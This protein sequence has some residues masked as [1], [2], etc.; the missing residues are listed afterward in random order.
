MERE[1]DLSS[2]QSTFQGDS[3]LAVPPNIE[4]HLMKHAQVF[5]P[6]ITLGEITEILVSDSQVERQL[7]DLSLK[8]ISWSYKKGHFSSY[9]IKKL[10][11]KEGFSHAKIYGLRV[12]TEIEQ[13]VVL[14]DEI[15]ITIQEW[16]RQ[17]TPDGVEVQVS[18]P[19]LLPKWKIPR[20]EGILFQVASSSSSLDKL[21]SVTLSALFEGEEISQKQIRLRLTLFREAFVAKR[22]IR[23]GTFITGEQVQR[24]RVDI[25]TFRGNEVIDEEQF[26]G[27]VARRNI[28]V[29]KAL[30]HLDFEEP[31]AIMKGSSNQITLIN[32][33]VQMNISRAIAL[34][35]GKR[36]EFILFQNPLNQREPIRAEV[37]DRGVARILIGKVG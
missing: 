30:S 28:Q 20:M 11:A 29:G 25:S 35:D 17:R 1:V 32:Q 37:I 5:P 7:S 23:K 4:I 9:Q 36:G 24:E 33:G 12:Y 19:S 21:S 3:L 13:R 6:S 15:K 14:P 31:V 18:L 22:F 8:P 16:I 34:Q 27:K 2:L 10:L 26:R